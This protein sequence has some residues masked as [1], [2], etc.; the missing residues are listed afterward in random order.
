MSTLTLPRPDTA[1][2]P[3]HRNRREPAWTRP[4]L[5]VLL[6][7]TAVLYL[8]GLSAS[9]NANSFY[10]AAVQA[11]TKS[12]KAL[13]FG[14]IDSSNFITVD[15]P[16]AALW[17]MALSGRVFGYSSWSM[18]APQALEGVASVAL[19]YAAV[20]R[21]SGPVA[22]LLAGAV[23]ALTPVAVL[24]FRFN[25]PDALLTLLLV[26]AGYA[27]VRA[28]EVASTRW[29][30]LA[31]ALV[32]FGF[33]TKML[34]ALLVLPAFGLMYLVAAPTSLR[35]R[36]LHLLAGVAALVV[37]AGWWVAAVALW[38]ASSR[39]YIGGSTN[40]SVL[41][42]AFGYNGL[43]RIFGG[44]GNGGGGN[45]G[46]GGGG[47]NTGFGGATGIT[48]LFGTAMGTEISWLLPT[49]LL[50]LGAG[51]WLGWR[52]PRTDRFRA[53]LILW[54]G[55]LVVTGFVF[56]YMKGTIHPY[57]TVVL[58]P[59]IGALVAV[60]GTRL[61]R[62]RRHIVARGLLAALVA[63]TAVWDYSLLARTPGWHP[64]L[65][66]AVLAG[67]V[68]VAAAM[69]LGAR[70]A[71]RAAVPVA[72]L[73]VVA[74][75]LGSAAYAQATASVPHSGSI[76]SSGPSGAGGMGGPDGMGG[77]PG[78]GF[79]G[80]IQSGGTQ[81]GGTQSGG[82]RGGVGEQ[83]TNSALVSLLK[84]TNTRWAAATVGAQSAAT[85][86]LSSGTAVMAI[87]GFTGSDPAPTLAQ[88]QAYVAQGK[89]RYFVAGGGMG[90]G[91]GGGNSEIS[92][93]V[94]AHYTSTTVGG[95]TVYDLTKKTS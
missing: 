39:P 26:A 72:A 81:S 44:S 91:P 83:S 45:G 6:A 16:P 15:K 79:P 78:G 5:L 77:G 60:V 90:G 67:G 48:R 18:L 68:L 74:G 55:W 52:A 73:A 19:L 49:A 7:A 61:W 66:Y 85:L 59:A 57:Y 37:A 94:A 54:G 23:L 70:L 42:L 86:E 71:R 29:V 62:E 88:F 40:N 36:L 24:M 58:A 35:R 32:G 4:A 82:M 64:W 50:A 51:L 11:G 95:Q 69:L 20:R 22:G 12:W 38:P 31:G 2:Q 84:A 14:S 1:E 30:V 13:F 87:G 10:A 34:Q 75:L 27:M 3:A 17:V 25:N 43:G 63:V 92:S 53:A 9:G 65:R 56:S 46:P 41:D 89:V 47:G 28:V 80:G 33:L 8:W 76:P 93:W 21:W